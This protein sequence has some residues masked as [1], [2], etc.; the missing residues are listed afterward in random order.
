[1]NTELGHGSERSDQDDRDEMN[2]I[3][4][5]SLDIQGIISGCCA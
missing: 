4:H 1:M 5:V 2:T 3:P